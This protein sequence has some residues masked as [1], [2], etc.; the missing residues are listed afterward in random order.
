ME[1]ALLAGVDDNKNDN[2]NNVYFSIC[3]RERSELRK[4][5]TKEIGTSAIMGC[6]LPRASREAHLVVESGMCNIMR[7]TQLRQTNRPYTILR[8]NYILNP[9]V[10]REF[11]LP[12]SSK[13]CWK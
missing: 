3:E 12:H 4:D 10:Y 8:L 2:S 1:E 9:F 7:N 6:M 11:W 13:C 5:K